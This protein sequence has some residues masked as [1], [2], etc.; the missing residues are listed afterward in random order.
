VPR[1]ISIT[2]PDIPLNGKLEVQFYDG[3]WIH[4]KYDLN[5]YHA[6]GSRAKFDV[7]S[8]SELD[9]FISCLSEDRGGIKKFVDSSNQESYPAPT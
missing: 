9:F 8:K 1:R 5:G 4:V 3:T 7:D 6:N 2:S